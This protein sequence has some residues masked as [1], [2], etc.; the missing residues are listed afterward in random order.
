MD[1]IGVR[2]VSITSAV[3]LSE[4]LQ[5]VKDYVSNIIARLDPVQEEKC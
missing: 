2:K 1:D 4:Y 3:L 5:R